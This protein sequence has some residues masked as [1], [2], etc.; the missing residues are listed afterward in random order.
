MSEAQPAYAAV[1]ED[2]EV[3]LPEEA[4]FQVGEEIEV[5]DLSGVQRSVL[6]AAKDVRFEVMSTSVE[7]TKSG[8]IK[9]LKAKLR[10][11]NG[12]PGADPE[13]GELTMQHANKIAFPGV[14]D[15]CIWHDPNGPDPKGW[16]KQQDAGS[17]EYLLGFRKFSEALGFDIKAI[18]VNDEYH[19]KAAGQHVLGTIRHETD[20]DTGQVSERFGNWK[21]APPQEE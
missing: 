9:Y 16:W 10:I 8:H 17:R 14:L 3:T 12:I 5:G 11:V 21:A 15:L 2:Q 6:P 1:Y 20:K 19:L 4:P 18:K 13:T 7:T